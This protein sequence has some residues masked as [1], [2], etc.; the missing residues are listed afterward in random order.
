MLLTVCNT[1]RKKSHNI[2]NNIIQQNILF[3]V[4]SFECMSGKNN[5]YI[6]KFSFLEFLAFWNLNNEVEKL[7]Y[8]LEEHFAI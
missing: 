3:Y 1:I 4:K 8:A 2:F 7:K 5:Q 6:K